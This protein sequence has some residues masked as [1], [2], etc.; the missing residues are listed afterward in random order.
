MILFFLRGDHVLIL[1]RITIYSFSQCLVA[2]L[3]KAILT[4]LLDFLHSNFCND[5]QFGV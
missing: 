4:Q 3:K 1:K 5:F 2:F